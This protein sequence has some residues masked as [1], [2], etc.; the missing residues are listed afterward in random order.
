[1]AK[2]TRVARFG[3]LPSADRVAERVACKLLIGLD[4]L[5]RFYTIA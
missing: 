1:M 3:C 4:L 2:G 5:T